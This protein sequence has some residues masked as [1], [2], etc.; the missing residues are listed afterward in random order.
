MTTLVILISISM[1]LYMAYALD[2][3][4][5]LQMAVQIAYAQ[6]RY[7]LWKVTWMARRWVLVRLLKGCRA[8]AL[9]CA[10]GGT[11]HGGTQWLT[12]RT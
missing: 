5:H 3:I 4:G 8:F 1:V 2:F 7:R 6:C 9:A 11:Q 12:P 10:D